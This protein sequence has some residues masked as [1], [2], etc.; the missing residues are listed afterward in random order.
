MELLRWGRSYCKVTMP[1]PHTESDLDGVKFFTQ[2]L[3]CFLDLCLNCCWAHINFCWMAGGHQVNACC[4]HSVLAESHLEVS[5]R[6]G[7]VSARTADSDWSESYSVP[8]SFMLSNK[9]WGNGRRK[10]VFSFQGGY[11][12]E[13]GR[14]PPVTGDESLLLYHFFFSRSSV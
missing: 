3:W 2:T 11:C 1:C 9:I 8:Y 14:A 5:K 12:L 4:F 6:V 13:T 10:G 7:G